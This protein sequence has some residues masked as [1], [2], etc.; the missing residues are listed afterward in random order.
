MSSDE[1]NIV[2]DEE[3]EVDQS[4]SNSEVA[5]KYKTAGQIA[6]KV[7]AKIISESTPG[8]KVLDLCE[9][10]DK[11]ILEEVSACYKSKKDLQKGIAFPTCISVNHVCGHYSPEAGD[12]ATLNDGDV[13]KIDLGVHLDGYIAVSAHTHVVGN[14]QTKPTTGKA[15]DV[16][17]AA[18]IAGEAV[19]KLLKPGS[20]NTDITPVIK[21]IADAYKVNL[22]EAVLSHQLKRFV[23]DG[24]K[25]IPNRGLADQAVE[26]FEVA[27]NDVFAIDIVT[28][29]G[30]GKTRENELRPTIFKRTPDQTYLLKL[31]AARTVF[32]EIKTNFP[33]FPF[34][35]R[36]L[37]EKHA[38]FGLGELE[39]HGLL[40]AYPI[41]Y[42]KEGDI[43]AQYKFTA[44]VG[45]SGALRITEQPLPYVQSQ[46]K[47]EDPEIQ[48]LLSQTVVFKKKNKKK[49]NK[50]AKTTKTETEA[51][52]MDTN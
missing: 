43:V 50:K 46:Y 41:L 42:E 14:S 1:E 31:Q 45:P 9:L 29:T 21:T 24:T 8:K 52:P 37:E 2:S 7:I 33:S 22:V 39:K 16:I 19:L 25:V 15:A 3:Q 17:C 48:K 49:S 23:I 20:R 36:S 40:N 13:V 35:I 44:L 6:N 30:A 26:E 11:L 38:R 12:T 18:Q 5:V 51:T 47:V 28:T 34:T 4:L 27:V 10:G 32:N